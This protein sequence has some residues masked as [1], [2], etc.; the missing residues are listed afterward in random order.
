MGFL[1]PPSSWEWS[2]EPP[3]TAR[4]TSAKNRAGAAM[5]TFA[6][7][8]IALMLGMSF[9]VFK[10]WYALTF[11][12]TYAAYF[13]ITAFVTNAPKLPR[14]GPSLEE[15]GARS[16]GR[17]ERLQPLFDLASQRAAPTTSK[18]PCAR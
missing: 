1:S 9:G 13:C 2:F 11:F 5:G 18:G 16:S 6:I 17:G 14:D 7:A 12:V 8:N 4:C 15:G 10:M 3:R